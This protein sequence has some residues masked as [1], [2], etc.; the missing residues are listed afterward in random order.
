MSLWAQKKQFTYL[1]VLSLLIIVI[2]SVPIYYYFIK[3]QDTCFDGI[4]NQNEEGIDCGGICTKVCTDSS[5]A[6]L[7]H[8]QRFFK[9]TDG[10]YS[11]ATEVENPNINVYAESIPYRFRFYDDNGVM[12][13]ERTGS[14]F[15]LPNTIFP[16]FESGIQTGQRIPVRVSFEFLNNTPD[17]QKKPYQLPHLVIIDQTQA[18]S[19][20]VTASSSAKIEATIQNETDFAANNIEV[21]A[22]VY[23]ANNNAIAASHTIV[24]QIDARSSTKVT[25]TWPTAFS[26]PVAKIEIVPKVLP[27]FNQ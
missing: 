9:V 12:I 26:S 14:T 18:S 6:P 17:W 1:S 21:V 5:Q 4:K 20:S 22:L 15:M 25:F 19:T 27:R 7:V 3:H 16:I 23:D 10:V 13:A 2:L 8:W 24:D 11:A